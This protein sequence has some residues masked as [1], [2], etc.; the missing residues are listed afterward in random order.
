MEGCWNGVYF[1]SVRPF[2][3]SGN[4]SPNTNKQAVVSG[5][6]GLFKN[7][8]FLKIRNRKRTLSC[9]TK[10]C[11]P[12]FFPSPT[13]MLMYVHD[14]LCSLTSR[15]FSLFILRHT[16]PPAVVA[17]GSLKL[18]ATATSRRTVPCSCPGHSGCF[19][20]AP[21]IVLQRSIVCTAP[22]FNLH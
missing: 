15:Y 5:D 10:L 19:Q 11:P 7:T 2:S 22:N 17:L 4:F 16:P 12:C 18:Q 6:P 8:N 14:G 1:C 9:I 13:H 3:H 21:C 20:L